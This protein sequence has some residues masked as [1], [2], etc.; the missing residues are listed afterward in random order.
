M[1]VFR[2]APKR[3]NKKNNA[4]SGVGGH[5]AEG[6]WHYQGHRVVYTASTRSLAMLERL[7]NDTSEIL[8]TDLSVTTILIPDTI[9]IVQYSVSE[10]DK[11]WDVTPYT[12]VTQEV[13]TAWF[14]SNASSVLR[15]PSSLCADEYNYIINPE[16]EDVGLIKC[17]DCQPFSYPP[18]LASTLNP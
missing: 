18:R 3:H 1:I 10:L 6:R 12:P 15:V 8:S 11:G 17:V 16:H 4:L 14:K 5:Y 9:K 2:I 7:V 13:G